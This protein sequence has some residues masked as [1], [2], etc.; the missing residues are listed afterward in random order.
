M[1]NGWKKNAVYFPEPLND[2]EY[3]KKKNKFRKFKKEYNLSSSCRFGWHSTV[4]MDY[5]IH[6]KMKR[7]GAHY[8]DEE[9]DI[10]HRMNFG[11]VNNW[12]LYC[13]YLF[14]KNHSNEKYHKNFIYDSSSNFKLNQRVFKEEIRCKRRETRKNVNKS[15]VFKNKP[16]KE[17]DD[18]TYHDCVVCLIDNIPSHKV[19]LITCRRKQKN[20]NYICNTCKKLVR[21]STTNKCP[22]CRKHFI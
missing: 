19:S 18:I 4:H 2:K 8:Y 14:I 16:K 12:S 7:P 20:K 21:E 17:Y 13:K 6:N 15:I 11:E 5:D 9:N 1:P 3:K 22:L 10:Y